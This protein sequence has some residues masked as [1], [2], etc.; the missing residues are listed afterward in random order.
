MA[1]LPVVQNLVMFIAI[2]VILSNLP[3]DM[4]YGWL[5][6]ARAVWRL[7]R[8]RRD[9]GLELVAGAAGLGPAG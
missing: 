8:L 1:R 7:S 3:V 2:V 9:A 6:P 4:L 5:R